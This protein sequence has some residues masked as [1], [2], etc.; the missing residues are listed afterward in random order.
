MA[1][2]NLEYLF[3]PVFAPTIYRL[4]SGIWFNTKQK[5][6]LAILCIYVISK[7]AQPHKGETTKEKEN[8]LQ[9]GEWT[10]QGHSGFTQV[11]YL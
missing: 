2:R 1:S 7:A 6:S 8:E 3:N 5:Y 4:K 10:V 9:L 11:Q